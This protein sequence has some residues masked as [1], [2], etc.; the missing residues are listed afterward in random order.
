MGCPGPRPTKSDWEWL[1]S[2]TPEQIDEF[3]RMLNQPPPD[4]TTKTDDDRRNDKK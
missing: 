1:A 3:V 4:N 2:R